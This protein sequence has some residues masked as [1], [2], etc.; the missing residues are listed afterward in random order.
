LNVRAKPFTSKEI[1]EY[2]KNPDNKPTLDS[3]PVGILSQ[4]GDFLIKNISVF[5]K[6]LF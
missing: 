1:K 4:P 2:E 6:N 3:I 5:L